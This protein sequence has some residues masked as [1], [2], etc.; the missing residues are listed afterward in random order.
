MSKEITSVENKLSR[1]KELYVRDL[2][3]I[4]D[5]EKDYKEYI[6]QLNELYKKQK[7]IKINTPDTNLKVLK[8]FLNNDFTLIYNSLSRKEKRR[9][10]LSMIDFI[11]ID[12]DY[13]IEISF[14]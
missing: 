6:N 8:S 13:N 1:L 9:L 14:I 12:K 11:I 5:Y 2:I 3:R 10:W 7:K 4:E